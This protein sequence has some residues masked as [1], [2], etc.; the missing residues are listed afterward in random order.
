MT[1]T[2]ILHD[3]FFSIKEKGETYSTTKTENN[4]SFYYFTQSITVYENKPNYHI[5]VYVKNG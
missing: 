2:I 4:I 1:I 3:T 5:I